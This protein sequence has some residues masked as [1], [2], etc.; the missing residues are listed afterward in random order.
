MNFCLWYFCVRVF[1][2][3]LQNIAWWS[4]NTI[5]SMLSCETLSTEIIKVEVFDDAGGGWRELTSSYD[6]FIVNIW[7]IEYF[8]I[9]QLS[10]IG[11]VVLYTTPIKIRFVFGSIMSKN[12]FSNSSE[13]FSLI[14]LERLFF[15][16]TCHTSLLFPLD[17]SI[18]YPAIS[19][20]SSSTHT[21]EFCFDQPYYRRVDVFLRILVIR[22]F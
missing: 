22:T 10:W 19:I 14:L 1:L 9:F 11:E 7:R 8:S 21:V 2:L 3:L 17:S 15:F 20:S 16:I 12:I 18:V 5:F 13:K 6:F 4:D